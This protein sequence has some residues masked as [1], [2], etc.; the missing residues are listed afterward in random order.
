[1][2][3]SDTDV[4]MAGTPIPWLVIPLSPVTCLCTS[5]RRAKDQERGFRAAGS[6]LA[7][8]G[9]AKPAGHERRRIPFVHPASLPK[10]PCDLIVIV[11]ASR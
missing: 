2:P 3:P 6:I 9:S 5:S 4:V 1:M 11:E 7:E 10:S 8:T